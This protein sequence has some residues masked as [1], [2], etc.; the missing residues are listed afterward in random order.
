VVTT[1]ET[2][3]MVTM[4]I[5]TCVVMARGL[6]AVTAAKTEVVAAVEM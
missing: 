6:V 5:E 2:E 1:L 4:Q 3:P